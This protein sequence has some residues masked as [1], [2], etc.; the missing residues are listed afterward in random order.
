MKELAMTLTEVG[1]TI[2]NAELRRAVAKVYGREG[3]CTDIKLK[4]DELKELRR[5]VTDSW[6]AVIL[7]ANPD[8]V[9][10]FQA[11]GIENYHQF[12]H[13]LDHA[14]LWTTHARTLESAQVDVIRSFSLFDTLASVFPKYRISSAM[15]PYGDLNRPRINWRLVRPGDGTDIGPIHADYWFDAVLDGWRHEPGPMVKLRV[16]IPIYIEVGVTGFAYVPESHL[17]EYPFRRARTGEGLLKPDFSPSDLNR[18]LE[19]LMISPGT[20]VMFSYNL[21]HRGANSARAKKTRVS[22]EMS[23]NLPRS[24]VEV[25][26]GDTCRYH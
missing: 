2:A 9:E 22:M 3:L 11:V 25:L 4:P 12:S 10:Q 1:G 7:K 23:L 8:L 5:V 6:L 26:C 21:V 15:P 16:W 19:T 20:A 24:D 18:P 17:H 13:L 14:N